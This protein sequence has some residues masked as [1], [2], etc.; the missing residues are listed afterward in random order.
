MK[1]ERV[2]IL[3]TVMNSYKNSYSS[4]IW[5]VNSSDNGS[6]TEVFDSLFDPTE[7]L[8]LTHPE[9]RLCGRIE[10]VSRSATNVTTPAHCCTSSFRKLD[11][12]PRKFKLMSSLFMMVNLSNSVVACTASKTLNWTSS[13]TLGWL[14][15]SSI[16]FGDNSP[17]KY[18]SLMNFSNTSCVTELLTCQNV[19]LRINSEEG[20]KAFHVRTLKLLNF[21]PPIFNWIPIGP[22]TGVIFFVRLIIPWYA[23]PASGYR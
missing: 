19:S 18:F 1:L 16:S 3:P 21:S 2:S 4:N 23:G 10:R 13:N 9:Y 20:E 11:F 12:L 6:G 22:L 15:K 17:Q 7:E 8:F 14:N 5:S